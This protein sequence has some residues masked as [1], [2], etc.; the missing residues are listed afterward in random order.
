MKKL[1]FFLSI[2]AGAQLAYAQQEYRITKSA[3]QLQLNFTN[4]T[5]EGYNGK[6]II[7]QG[8]KV[9]REETDKRAAGLV[10]IT[11]SG[12]SD[13]TGMGISVTEKGPDVIVNLAARKA[14]AIGTVHIKVPE[15]MKVAIIGTRGNLYVDNGFYNSQPDNI[16]ND[17]I[18]KNLKNELEIS[19]S[20]N[21]VLLEN[22]TGPMNIKTVN[23]AVEA[24]FNS[25]IKGPLSIVSALG[26]VDVTLPLQTKANLQLTTMNG[27]I[28]ASQDFKIDFEKQPDIDVIKTGAGFDYVFKDNIQTSPSIRNRAG[29]VTGTGVIS[30]TSDNAKVVVADTAK[31]NKGVNIS[32]S[33]SGS[34]TGT[35]SRDVEMNAAGSLTRSFNL[36]SSLYTGENV[37]GKIN[38]GGIDI[39]LRSTGKSVY[40]RNK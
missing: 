19:V 32:K 27:K 4:V 29:R 40:L 7:F 8:E 23:G 5:V 9:E 26:Y 18:V 30:Q 2:L 6:E 31:I 36:G 25:E 37:K 39:V 17:I 14:K 3:G 11:S 12:Y 35:A 13:N 38:G 16:I 28:Y 22:N 21:K 15:N 24:M 33:V 34:I 1:V 10:P 20:N